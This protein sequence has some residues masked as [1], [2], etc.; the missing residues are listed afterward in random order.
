MVILHRP[1]NLRVSTHPTFTN[2]NSMTEDTKRPDLL[3]W[4]RTWQE[5][6]VSLF[7]LQ[8]ASLIQLLVVAPSYCWHGWEGQ[9]SGSLRQMGEGQLESLI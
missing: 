9:T 5:G 4:I 2:L 6:Y 1:G 7:R 3:L 8:P